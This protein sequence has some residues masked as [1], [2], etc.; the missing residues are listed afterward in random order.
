MTGTRFALGLLLAGALSSIG[1]ASSEIISGGVRTL[2]KA[3]V[4]DEE[5][6]KLG[7]QL[8]DELLKKNTTILDDP[9][10][11]SYLRGITDPIFEQAKRDRPGVNWTL[12][13]IDDPGT[14]NAFSAPGGGLYVYSG[15]LAAAHNDSEVAG[16]L[17]HEVGHEVL[18]HVAEKLVAASGLEALTAVALGNDPSMLEQIAAALLGK[19][20]L[21]AFS[22]DEERQA[23]EYGARVASA[24]GFN[25]YG[26]VTFFQTLEKSEGAMPGVLRFLS[27]HPLTPDRIANIE[28][29]IKEERLPNTDV[30]P[31]TERLREIQ[32]RLK[33]SASRLATDYS[34][35]SSRARRKRASSIEGSPCAARAALPALA[36]NQA[37]S[38]LRAAPSSS[39]ARSASCCRAWSKARLRWS[40]A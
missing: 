25:P 20:A 29:L 40:D 34:C 6:S 31:Q 5:E 32:A 33:K 7:A 16:V 11:T 23:D 14:L 4:S 17:G 35:A 1:C 22:R 8:H 18:H 28:R 12:Y 36:P 26:L 39:R 3:L 2:A 38:A 37:G 15:L 9:E 10:V 30:L 27:D 24:A 21:L 19:G 13:V